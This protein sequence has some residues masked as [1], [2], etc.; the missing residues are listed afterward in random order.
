MASNNPFWT[1]LRGLVGDDRPEEDPAGPETFGAP[2][3]SEQQPAPVSPIDPF[4]LELPAEHAVHKLYALW[5]KQA[6]WQPTPHF[7]FAGTD[8]DNILSEADAG[9][10]LARLK[11]SVNASANKRL[12]AIVPPKSN[13]GQ[14]AP[15]PD[16]D[17]AVEV[18]VTA[19]AMSAWVYAYP[20]VGEGRELDQQ[21][22]ADALAEAKVVFG[23]DEDKVEALPGDAKRY[24]HLFP[25]ARGRKTISGKDG[26]IVDLF[27]R[28]TERKIK[29]DEFNR[30][31]YAAISFVQN[32]A[33]GEPIC[34]I[35]P[36][37]QA[38]PGCTVLGRELPSRD[39]VAAAIPKGRNTVL[40][41][42]GTALL[43]AKTGHVE[44]N[45]RAF[46]VR[47][48]LEIDGNVDFSSGNINFL[49]D[50]HVHGDVCTGFT[51]RAMGSVTVDG[52]VEASTVEAGADLIIVKG[53]QGDGRAVLRASH[54]IFAKY[55]ESCCVYAV[56]DLHADSLINCDVYC[57]GT[58]E[59]NSGRG[60]IIGGSIRCAH[61][62]EATIVGS[63]AETATEIALGGAPCQEFDR[64]VLLLEI[65]SLET[66]LEAVERQPESPTKFARMGKLR[67][68]ISVNKNKLEQFQE[69]LDSQEEEEEPGIRRLTCGVAYPGVTVAIGPGSYRFRRETRPVTAYLKEGGEIAII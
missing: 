18:F 15:A 10:A 50:V 4:L 68:Q 66:E 61:E 31:D 41:E 48:V 40:S 62:V 51:V 39:G 1:W 69:D 23:I 42:D 9:R 53:A 54:S 55:L 20:P 64:E 33:E 65:A 47:P 2:E 38:E 27:S 57:D 11:M 56:E 58:V 43:A 45:G 22:I 37:D 7:S 59:I 63:R 13:D 21:M 25:V 29:T 6:G 24:F 49:G 60:A 52:V 28:K 26:R 5:R 30:V 35:I 14:E 17:A 36:P 16:V 3:V 8:E 34:H 44:F 67:M 12:K 32:V 19:D 46:Q